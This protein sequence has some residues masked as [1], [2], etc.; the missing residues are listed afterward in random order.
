MRHFFLFFALL[1]SSLAQAGNDP[2][3]SKPEFLPVDKAF[4][5]TSQRLDSGE[6]Q[7]FWQIADGYYLYQKRLK[8][9]GLTTQNI[10]A[11]PEGESHSDEYFGEQPVY[12]QGLELKIPAAATG[13]IKVS[14]QGCADAGLCYPPQ[15]RV[16]DLGGKAAAAATDEAPDQALASGLQ[17]HSLGW[18]L[19]VFFGLGLL[20]A[21]APCSL[22]ML[23]ILAGMVVGSGAT[24]RRGFALAGSYVVCMALVYAAMGVIAALLGANLQAWLQNPWLLGTFAAVFVVLAL[25]MFGFFELQ[26]PVALRDRL[27]H[28]SRSQR[29][30]SLVGAGILGALSGLLVGP[31][32]TAPLAGALLYIAQS[33]N[34]LHG[35]LILFALG[36][37]IG[38]PLLL[39]V[40]VGNRFLPK[41]GAWMNLLKGVFGFLFLATALLMLRPVLDPSLWLG[42]CGALLLI[43]A[44][45]AWKQ[46]EGFGRVAQLFG[47]GSLLLGLWG[48]LLVVGAAGG[49]EDPYQ[50]LQV[51]SAG[52]V[53][54]AAPN[55][56][57]AFTTIKDPA[58]LQRELDT[59]KAQGQWVLLD[60]Y[61]DWCVSCKVMEKQVFG[62]ARVMQ[63]LSDVRLLRLDVTADNAASRELLGRYKVPGPPSFVWIGADGEERRSQRITGEVDADTFLQRWTTTRD[64]R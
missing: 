44:Y 63:A 57:E 12:R 49:S 14:Y 51:Y 61:A 13:Q 29:G 47:A 23:P 21:F 40:T 55:G 11:L 1:I 3:A 20:L 9:D 30:G 31:C 19:L 48:S 18:S 8:F 26:L 58:A 28:A 25:P 2:F 34:A 39:L 41:P 15:T 50:P 36:I 10:P 59:A 43:A 52:R 60:Y 56:H 32:M 22:P 24:P 54:T 4:V 17:Q 7:L 64:A 45:S 38:V 6:T 46:S 62:Q 35:G 42:L 16:I 53:G 27:E 33:G 5:L 37:G